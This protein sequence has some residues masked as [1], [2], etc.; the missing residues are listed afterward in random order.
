MSTGT[1]GAIKAGAAYVQ[2]Y[3][4]DNPLT[5]GL[6]KLQTKLKGWQASMSKLGASAYGGELPEPFAALAR[7]AASPAGAF[8]ALLGA[9]KY[10]AAAR[11][12]MLKMSETTG[13]AVDKLSALSYAARRA[14]VSNEALASGLQR[15]QSKEFQMAMQGAGR[16]GVGG[17]FRG[18]GGSKG[19]GGGHMDFAAALG[20]DKHAGA[21][22]QL[23]QIV[24][25]FEKLDSM[26]RIGLAK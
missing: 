2:A 17:G 7:F 20:L 3:L 26:S 25:Q 21:D 12:E 11:E 6:A 13:V 14:G 15:L 18:A 19:G 9:A 22:E 5:Q 4:D 8:S 16:G 10:T 1:T 23:R 24:K